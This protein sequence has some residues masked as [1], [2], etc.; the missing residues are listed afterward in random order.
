VSISN[1]FDNL[2]LT[3]LVVSQYWWNIVVGLTLMVNAHAK[4]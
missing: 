1:G 3:S 4:S 2:I